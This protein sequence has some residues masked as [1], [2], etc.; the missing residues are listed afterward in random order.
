MSNFNHEMYKLL[1]S[2]D[3]NNSIIFIK[4]ILYKYRF[5]FL[6]L[7]THIVTYYIGT[8]ITYIDI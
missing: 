5:N 8:A 6:I 7:F 3:M 2:R 1:I 4:V